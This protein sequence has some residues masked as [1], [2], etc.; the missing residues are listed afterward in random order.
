MIWSRCIA[1]VLIAT[2]S[3]IDAAEGLKV[4]PQLPSS[5]PERTLNSFLGL[6]YHHVTARAPIQI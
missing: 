3:C 2:S 5:S 4:T 6:V 1:I